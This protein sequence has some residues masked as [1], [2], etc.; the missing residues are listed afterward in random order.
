MFVKDIR[1][2]I[3]SGNMVSDGRK[4]NS[5]HAAAKLFLKQILFTYDFDEIH[6]KNPIG[7]DI[8]T[9]QFNTGV[10]ISLKYSFLNSSQYHYLASLFRVSISI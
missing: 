10:T 8:R 2:W 5:I 3:Y 7:K 1:G 6:Y 4:I 9:F